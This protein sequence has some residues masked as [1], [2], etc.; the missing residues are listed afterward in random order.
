M[1]YS[2]RDKYGLGPRHSLVHAFH[3]AIRGHVQAI[4]ENDPGDWNGQVF[5]VL[6][7]VLTK[8]VLAG[9]EQSALDAGYRFDWS[10][11]VSQRERPDAYKALEGEEGEGFMFRHKDAPIGEWAE[12]RKLSGLG[13]NVVRYPENVSGTAIY[14][15]SPTQVLQYLEDGVPPDTI[16][17]IDDSGG[18]LTAPIIMH[19]KGVICAG[20]STRSHLGILTREYGVPCVMNARVA[21]IAN[22]DRVEIEVTA[23]AK[24]AAAY[25]QGLE[26]TANIWRLKS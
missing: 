5:G 18:T 15:R 4:I 20:G 6:E 17:M 3:S 11:S 2:D 12:G 1:L 23:P 26:M 22:G 10:A 9:V 19:F 8:D 21:G 14:V 25:Q 7:K 13:D 24:T 16:A